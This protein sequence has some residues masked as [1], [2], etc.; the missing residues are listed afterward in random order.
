M[1]LG[2]NYEG[3]LA[4]IYFVPVFCIGYFV[5][6]S[7]FIAVLVGNFSTKLDMERELKKRKKLTGK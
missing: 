2:I 5:I 7:V 1:A 6:R 4:V 3:W